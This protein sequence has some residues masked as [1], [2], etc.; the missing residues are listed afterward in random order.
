MGMDFDA[1]ISALAEV[2]YK[3][4][5]TLEADAYLAAYKDRLEEGI[6]NLASAAR[7]F[8]DKFDAIKAKNP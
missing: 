2:D 3:G 6:K 4:Y 1:I 5:C 8:A 7:K